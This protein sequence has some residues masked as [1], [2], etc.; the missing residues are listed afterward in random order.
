MP[1]TPDKINAL[2]QDGLTAMSKLLK[3]RLIEGRWPARVSYGGDRYL[4]QVD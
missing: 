3:G 1:M 4:V 2:S